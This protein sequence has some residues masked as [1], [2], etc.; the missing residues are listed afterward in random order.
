[1]K[2]TIP[3]SLSEEAFLLGSLR[4]VTKVWARASGK[5]SFNFSVQ[6]GQAHLQLGFQLGLPGDPHIPP[7]ANPPPPRFKGSVRIERDRIR[8]AEHQARLIETSKST[9]SK[10]AVPATQSTTLTSTSSATPTTAAPVVSVVTSTSTSSSKVAAPVKE[11]ST[12]VSVVSA[13]STKPAVIT[14]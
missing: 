5:A 6:D 13:S 4:E 9:T 8:A 10:V 7:C 2:N 3:F 12:P 11:S 14:Q 1:M